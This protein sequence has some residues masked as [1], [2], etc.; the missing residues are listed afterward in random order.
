VTPADRN[1]HDYL[2]DPA[3]AADPEIARLERALA[4]L[5]HR[6]EV[7]AWPAGPRRLDGPS[8]GRR[9]PR[10][11]WPMA[12]AALAAVLLIAVGAGAWLALRSEAWEVEIL[13][14][15]PR[16]DGRPVDEG[17][18][19]R[20]GGRLATGAAGRARLALLLVGEVDVEPGSEVALLR[21]RPD[22]QRFR[23]LNGTL[24]ARIWAPPRVFQVDTPAVRAVDLGC[25]YE[26]TV[27][28]AGD[29]RLAVESGWVALVDGERESFVPAGA[30][31]AI[32]AARGSGI[33]LWDDAPAAL[34]RAVARLERERDLALRRPALA[35]ALAAARQPDALTVWH[36]LARAAPAE[37]AAVADR[38]AELAPPPPAAGRA[39]V[40]A[41]DRSALDAWW[42]TLELGA[43]S[44][45][46]LWR[47]T[48]P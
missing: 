41:G 26:L 29:G 16:I 48:V 1:D 13:A 36:L 12:L 38:L 32:D 18:R 30:W 40:L 31:A 25:V 17:G 22:A 3:A 45:W 23:L 24:R 11:R 20:P 39:A 33:P 42:N 14:G 34:R 7:P 47:Q 43:T 19:L 46:R 44:W 4:P 6:G 9:L 2:W 28:R 5:A 15:E 27:D 8:A 37:R 10:F 35:Q 21:S